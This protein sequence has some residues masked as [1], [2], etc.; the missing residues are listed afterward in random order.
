MQGLSGDFIPKIEIAKADL[1]ALVGQAIRPKDLEE[2][3]M[4][5]K[6][7]LEGVEPS[8]GM[9]KLDCKDTNRPD[10]WGVEGIAR[11]IRGSL[12]VETGAPRYKIE[13][14]G[15]VLEVDKK[16]AKVRPL[17]VGAVVHGLR[18]DDIAIQ[19]LIQLQEK[20]A[21]T[22]GRKRREAAIGVY[23]FAK[24]KPPIR[25]TTFKDDEIKFIPLDSTEPMSPKQ[26]LERH[27]KGKEYGHLIPGGDFPIL[28]DAAANVLS[29]PPVIN[30]VWTGKVTADTKDVFVEVTGWDARIIGLALNVVV[31]AL[32]ERGGRIES[33]TVRSAG[34]STTAPDLSGGSMAIEGSAVRRFLGLQLSDDEIAKLLR[35]ARY[36]VVPKGDRL[37]CIWPGYRLDIMH[38]RDI[39]E[40]A[41]IIFGYN[42]MQPDAPRIYTAGGESEF[43]LFCRRIKEAGIGLG[44]QEIMTFILTNGA[45]L[46]K[47]M[48]T[49]AMPVAEIANPVSASWSVLRN[50]L[51]PSVLEFFAKNMHV[52]YPQRIFELGDCVV[53][54]DRAETRTRTA[55]Q[56]CFAVSGVK[57]GYEDA[58]SALDALLRGL[59]ISYKLQPCSCPHYIDGRGAEVVADGTTLG[60]IGEIHPQVLN[61]WG[62]EKA[63]VAAE[64]SVDALWALV[65]KRRGAQIP[66]K[67]THKVL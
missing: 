2:L 20:V 3:L 39:I 32:A 16:V 56:L 46:F 15:I 33:V 50:W 47:N 28:I 34:K 21:L 7:E 37:T 31:T 35:R 43:E 29:M 51:T 27:P 9:L 10:L 11:Q 23:D 38:E 41:G 14:S 62:L 12:G 66:K 24:I 5:A 55:R 49:P 19:Q 22:W 63:V 30:G 42:E 44:F 18:F 26:I 25:Y 64:L 1:E 48:E 17:V 61:N 60:T 67:H 65:A 8:S 45:C 13:K 57:V 59:G 58:A 36:D 6:V 54:D 4:T 52:E 40:D 53:L